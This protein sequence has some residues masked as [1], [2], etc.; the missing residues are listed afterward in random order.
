MSSTVWFNDWYDECSLYDKSIIAVPY[1]KGT[2]GVFFI[3]KDFS[4][5]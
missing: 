5:T 1:Q 2:L 4:G 3:I